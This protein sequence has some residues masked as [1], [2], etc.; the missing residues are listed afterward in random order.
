MGN[1]NI[2]YFRKK[3]SSEIVSLIG[4]FID[5]DTVVTL[6]SMVDCSF[7]VEL[8]QMIEYVKIETEKVK[9]SAFIFNYL[10]KLVKVSINGNF[11]LDE[12]NILHQIKELNISNVNQPL[13]LSKLNNLNHLYLKKCSISDD[14]IINNSK[15]NNLTYLSL[16][17]CDELTKDLYSYIRNFTKLT[18]LTIKSSAMDEMND[19]VISNLS[20][21]TNL[22][23]LNLYCTCITDE[24][25]VNIS[26]FYPNLTKLNVSLCR[27]TNNC[28]DSISKITKLSKLNLRARYA[29]EPFL[30]NNLSI[31]KI[32][33]LQNITS[34]KLQNTLI[35]DESVKI[36][37][38]S[39]IN[40]VKLNINHTKITDISL[41]YLVNVKLEVLNIGSNFNIDNKSLK[42]IEKM[43]NIRKLHLGDCAKITYNG[44]YL[45]SSLTKLIHLVIDRSIISLDV[46]YNDNVKIKNNDVSE[47]MNYCKYLIRLNE[48]NIKRQK[49]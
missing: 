43:H 10:L 24:S 29:E 2:N 11:N 3:M 35:N 13:C 47:L 22:E 41:E 39:F 37:S 33:N 31:K 23:H 48:Q 5:I 26:T 25:I 45:L 6:S 15:F 8:T 17:N 34:L 36:I 21:L 16:I 28:L 9:D 18:Y 42:I 27:I 1:T 30:L 46:Q 19:T 38:E 14:V 7:L 44:L 49:V 32:I 12:L 40:L 4:S 20:T